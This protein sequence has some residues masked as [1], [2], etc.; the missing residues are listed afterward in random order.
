VGVLLPYVMEFNRPA[1]EPELAALG[2]ALGGDPI[3]VVADLLAAI[4]IPRTLAELG[5]RA[6]QLD[7]IAEL[8]MQS[9]RLVRNNPRELTVDGCREIVAAAFR[10]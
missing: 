1:I 2:G 4:G 10:G 6:D 3:D 9:G 7:Q 5:V 8:G